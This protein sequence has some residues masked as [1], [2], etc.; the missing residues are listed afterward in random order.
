MT[1]RNK[2]LVTEN[3]WRSLRR[4]TDARIGLGASAH[5]GQ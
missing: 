5:H 3:A 2:N 4:Y 1:D